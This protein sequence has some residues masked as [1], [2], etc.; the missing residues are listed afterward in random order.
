MTDRYISLLRHGEPQGGGR[1]RGG[2]DDPLSDAGWAQMWAQVRTGGLDYRLDRVV[3][4]PA[5]RCAEFARRLCEERALPLVLEPRLGER[6]FGDWEGLAAHQIPADQLTRF[7]DDPV[8]YTPPNAEPF[9]AFRDRV[10]AGW[11]DLLTGDAPH[12]LVIT[13]GG[14][15]RVILARLLGL[16]DDSGL[17]IEVPPAALSRVRV[18]MDPGRPSLMGHCGTPEGLG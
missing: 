12:T 10:L 14:G 17:L 13:H 3:S 1:F 15:V 8:A 9:S 6:R 2:H 7:W 5:R 18:P 4:S 16:A 11:G